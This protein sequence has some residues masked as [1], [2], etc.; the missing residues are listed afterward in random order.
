MS[1]TAISDGDGDTETITL[2]AR[3]SASNNNDRPKLLEPNNK[4]PSG[5]EST[6]ASQ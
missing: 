6:M 1:D 3:G 2:N 5:M 4:G